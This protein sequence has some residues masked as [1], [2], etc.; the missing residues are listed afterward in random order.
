MNAKK[1]TKK[2]T[3]ILFKFVSVHILNTEITITYTV[4]NVKSYLLAFE[5][6]S[7]PKI[8]EWIPATFVPQPNRET[9][10]LIEIDALS[11]YVFASMFNHHIEN[12]YSFSLTFQNVDAIEVIAVCI[13]LCLI[14]VL[15]QHWFRHW[16]SCYRN[17]SIFGR[18]TFHKFISHWILLLLLCPLSQ[19]PNGN[20]E[21]G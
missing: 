16:C 9:H 13:I 3:S 6:C 5:L 7:R 20:A 17:H 8:R 4:K 12:H 19:R 21:N 2:R 15:T 14:W 18:I 10:K 1:N 11:V